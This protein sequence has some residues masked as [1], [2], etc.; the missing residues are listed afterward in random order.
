MPRIVRLGD[1][2][3]HGGTVISSASK[4][5]CEGALIA[6]K[7]DLHSCPIP[8]HGVTAIVSGAGKYQCEGAPIA[9]EGDTCGCGAA[10]ISGA[11][12]WECE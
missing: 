8:G 4:W 5:R 1:T 9:R 6:R 7:G 12:K 2:S 3:S 10:L 11:S